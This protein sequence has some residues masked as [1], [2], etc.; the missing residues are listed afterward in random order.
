MHNWRLKIIRGNVE[1]SARAV[2]FFDGA[3]A[4]ERRLPLVEV[5]GEFGRL[6]DALGEEGG[7]VFFE[8]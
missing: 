7:V 4:G 1:D 2:A 8:P 6:V 5:G 3:A